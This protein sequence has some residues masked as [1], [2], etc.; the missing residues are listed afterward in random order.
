MAM[1]LIT[2]PTTE[3]C[4]DGLGP[5]AERLNIALTM[6]FEEII[7][8]QSRLALII[9]GR[10]STIADKMLGGCNDFLFGQKIL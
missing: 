4:H 7:F 8:G 9:S 1:E 2:I 10:G 3:T 5:N 6:N